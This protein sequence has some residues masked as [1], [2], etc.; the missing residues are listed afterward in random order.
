L[1]KEGTIVESRGENA[2]G[3]V[4]MAIAVVILLVAIGFVATPF[5]DAVA[6]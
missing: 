1:R 2:M 3:C 5:L 4:L 6:P